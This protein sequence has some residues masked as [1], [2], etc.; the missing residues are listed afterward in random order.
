[1][2][3]DRLRWVASKYGVEVFGARRSPANWENGEPTQ[4]SML[5]QSDVRW[6]IGIGPTQLGL[7]K[8]LG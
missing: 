2:A 3:T 7:H 8:Y 6:S 5:G 4:E 1:M